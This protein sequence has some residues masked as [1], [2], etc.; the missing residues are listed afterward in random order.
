MPVAYEAVVYA[1]APIGAFEVEVL[2]AVLNFA[3][4]IRQVW[5]ERHFLAPGCQYE[6]EYFIKL[7]I[8]TA[9]NLCSTHQKFHCHQTS[10]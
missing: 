1:A 7:F 5:T 2:L 10:N 8:T 6:I 3:L 9:N 4:Y